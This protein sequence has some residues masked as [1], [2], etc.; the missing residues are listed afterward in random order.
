MKNKLKI[1]SHHIT[2]HD[3]TQLGDAANTPHTSFMW[4]EIDLSQQTLR[5]IYGSIYK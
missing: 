2:S 1:T 4:T 5:Q 3:S